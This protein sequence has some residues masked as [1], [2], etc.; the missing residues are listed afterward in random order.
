MHFIGDYPNEENI[1]KCLNYDG[2]MNWQKFGYKYGETPHDNCF[3]KIIKNGGETHFVHIMKIYENGK[4]DI[5]D[6]DGGRREGNLN[7]F[8][9]FIIN[10]NINETL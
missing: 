8:N 5:F 4:C 7:E 2:D 3:G 1:K 9:A 10:Q 6:P